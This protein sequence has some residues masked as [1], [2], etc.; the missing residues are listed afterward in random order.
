MGV[1]VIRPLLFGVHIGAGDF[2]KSP[3]SGIPKSLELEMLTL[4]SVAG[5]CGRMHGYLAQHLGKN[6]ASLEL[7]TPFGNNEFQIWLS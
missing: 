2:L 3:L 4:G 6:L 1:L 7:Y 5:L